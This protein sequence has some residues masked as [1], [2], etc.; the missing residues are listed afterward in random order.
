MIAAAEHVQVSVYHGKINL[1]RAG[2]GAA[3]KWA[4]S[5]ASPQ[6]VAQMVAADFM[7]CS[8][9]QVRVTL[10]TRGDSISGEPTIFEARKAQS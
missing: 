5:S 3:G 10:V 4:R 1:A 2:I 7:G 6:G 8:R 9:H